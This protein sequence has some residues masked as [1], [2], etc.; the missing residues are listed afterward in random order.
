M[1]DLR[2][3]KVFSFPPGLN[4]EQRIYRFLDREHFEET[5]R[6]KR[7]TFVRPN[8]WEDTWDRPAM[9]QLVHQQ[10]PPATEIARECEED[11]HV[12]CWS[13]ADP[14]D[15]LW[16]A[17][18]YI[19]RDV[20]T[21]ARLH[22]SEEAVR[23]RSTISKLTI[24]FSDSDAPTDWRLFV[25]QVGYYT[26][27]EITQYIANQVGTFGANAFVSAAETAAVLLRKRREFAQEN[28]IRLIIADPS[29]DPSSV[30]AS[31]SFE[32]NGVFEEVAFDPR[33]SPDENR[34]ST[35]MLAALGYAGSVAP[36]TF[37]LGRLYE[38]LVP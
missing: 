34:E 21:G 25:G 24:A 10:P 20:E 35:E 7:L 17:Y 8:K 19:R 18:S 2:A 3:G 37:R 4:P 28:E 31:I 29:N 5:L 14:S 22:P 16:R 38:I 30:L 6:T 23:V 11:L 15:V 32:P 26:D 12:Q 1:P 33:I 27:E 13:A 36:N 9:V